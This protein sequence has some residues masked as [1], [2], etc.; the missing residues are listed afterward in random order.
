MSRLILA[1]ELDTGEQCAFVAE[2][3]RLDPAEASLMQVKIGREVESLGPNH[4]SAPGLV[5]GGGALSGEI[6]SH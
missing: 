3:P 1:F 6:Q 4:W 2:G 5:I